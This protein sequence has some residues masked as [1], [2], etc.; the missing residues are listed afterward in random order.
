VARP[1]VPG[2][3]RNDSCRGGRARVLLA[4][5][6]TRNALPRNRCSA[7]V[8]ARTFRD[9]TTLAEGTL[10]RKRRTVELNAARPAPDH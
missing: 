3:L 6:S 4:V 10:D 1:L 9:C 5:P 7:A 2:D 8:G